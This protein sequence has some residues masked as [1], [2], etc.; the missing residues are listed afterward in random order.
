MYRRR[1]KRLPVVDGDG[2]LAGI[3]SRADVLTVFDRSDEEICG[4][5]AGNVIPDEFLAAPYA[6]TV[7]VKDGVVI[8]AG[9]SDT[10]EVGRELVRR[11]RVWWR[12]ATASATRPRAPRASP[13]PRSFLSTDARIGSRKGRHQRRLPHADRTGRRGAARTNPRLRAQTP[14]RSVGGAFDSEGYPGGLTFARHH[15][16]G[17]GLVSCSLAVSRTVS[18][19]SPYRAFSIFAAAIRSPAGI[20]RHRDS[21]AARPPEPA[22]LTSSSGRKPPPAQRPLAS[23][24]D[25]DPSRHYPAVG[26]VTV[27]GPRERNGD[28]GWLRAAT[29]ER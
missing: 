28:Q 1:V 13:S 18:S 9:K 10:S 14:R 2:H 20:H 5:I 26:V 19:S 15:L 3:I 23:P 12:S 17:S 7:T 25:P 11:V 8:L 6:F 16:G 27:P 4:E 29:G 22:S 21:P 24:A